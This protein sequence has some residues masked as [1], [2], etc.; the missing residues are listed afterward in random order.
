MQ[1]SKEHTQQHI[2]G[3]V[4]GFLNDYFF[5]I[6]FTITWSQK[7]LCTCKGHQDATWHHGFVTIV[8]MATCS[9]IFEFILIYL[10]DL[11]LGIKKYHFLL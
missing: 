10:N 3:F 8:N 9:I 7:L 1:S 4:T 5:S 2:L 6:I 11:K